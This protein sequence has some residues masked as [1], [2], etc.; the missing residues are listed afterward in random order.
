MSNITFFTPQKSPSQLFTWQIKKWTFH[1]YSCLHSYSMRTLITVMMFVLL[2][3]V[4]FA[5]FAHIQK[6]ADIKFL[7]ACVFLLFGLKW[8][9]SLCLHLLRSLA[10][11]L[12]VGLFTTRRADNTW[13]YTGARYK[14]IYLFI[15]VQHR[16]RQKNKK[17]VVLLTIR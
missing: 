3:K 10:N 11:H 15:L 4:V 8:N 13:L 7:K 17:F 6:N 16:A 12:L 9:L 14:V 1:K 2:K 5:T